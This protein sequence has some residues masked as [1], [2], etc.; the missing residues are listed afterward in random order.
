MLGWYAFVGAKNLS[1]LYCESMETSH[2]GCGSSR[3]SVGSAADSMYEYMLK[4]WL[5]S[6]KT[7]DVSFF[8]GGGG[9]GVCE[10]G[11]RACLCLCVF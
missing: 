4:Q 8:W 11:L 7:Q 5:M 10:M 6:N 2:L 3:V 9:Q 1:G